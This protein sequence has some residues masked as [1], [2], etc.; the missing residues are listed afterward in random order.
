MY[1]IR[2]TPGFAR[3][4][5]KFDKYTQKMLKNWISKNLEATENPREHGKQLTGQLGEYWRY[6]IGDYRLI[7]HIDDNELIILA[8]EVGHRREIYERFDRK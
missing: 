4:F 8:I 1:E 7:C 5:K 6:R 2:V 3:S